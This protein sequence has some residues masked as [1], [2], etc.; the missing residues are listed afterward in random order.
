MAIGTQRKKRTP[1]MRKA[2]LVPTKRA[3]ST[4]LVLLFMILIA[5]FSLTPILW[6]LSTAF[7]PASQVLSSPPHWIPRI[8]TLANFRAVLFQSSMPRYFLNSIVVASITVVV[9]VGIAAHAGYAAARFRFLGRQ[10]LMFFVL[11]TAMIPGIATLV[12]LY[13]LA[14]KLGLFNTFTAMIIVYT[15]WQIPTVVW[16]LK[17]FFETIPGDLEE[18]ALIDGCSRLRAFYQVVLPISQPG[19]AS[20]ALLSF[21]YVW[22][23]FLIAFTFVTKNNLKLVPVGLYNYLSQ[24]GIQWGQLMAAVILA[25]IPVIVLFAGLQT[26]FIEG[27]TAGGTKG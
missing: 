23:D 18:A 12:P 4:W 14:T 9:T 17:G 20:A 8:V 10:G 13:I 27:M 1:T 16:M 7:K 3:A 22:N 25:L 21:V 6:A 2:T 11:A 19:L 24:Y 26:R 5:V 15:A